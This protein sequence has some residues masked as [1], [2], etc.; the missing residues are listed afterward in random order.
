MA[1]I[2]PWSFSMLES[3][4]TCPFQ[5]Y[6]IRIA[7]TYKEDQ[8]K[9]YLLWGNAVHEA[10]EASIKAD[11][12]IQTTLT[13]HSYTVEAKELARYNGMAAQIASAPGDKYA[14]LET[15]VTKDLRPCGFWDV[16]CWNRGKE[17]LVI[18]NGRTIL[19]IDWKTGKR[20]LDSLQLELSAA[21]LM[22]KFPEVD[23]VI[24]AFAWLNTGQWDRTTFTRD[25]FEQIW[26][27]FFERV[28]DLEWS[29]KN[30]TWPQ[31]PSGLCKRSRKPGSTYMGCIVACCPHSEGYRK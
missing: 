19:D 20:K 28:A 29:E 13:K 21:R 6:H 4:N 9:S 26:E 7:K 8:N 23:K 2:I 5:F 10:M 18:V 1:G 30:N 27:G 24:T 31:K 12:P 17:D 16:D 22:V 3:Y 14:E 11:V 15:A 25:Q